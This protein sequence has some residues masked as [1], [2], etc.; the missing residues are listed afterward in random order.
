MPTLTITR[1]L[2]ASGKTTWARKY[3]ADTGAV[4]V[5]R[6][7]LRAMMFDRL[8]GLTWEEEKAVT[9]ASR[10]LTAANVNAGR[11]VVA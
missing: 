10:A 3:A 1:G 9:D 8:H 11:D 5:N 2:P 6:D 7:D 4:R